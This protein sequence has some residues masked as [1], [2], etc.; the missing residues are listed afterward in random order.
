MPSPDTYL[1]L[2][3][4]LNID[5]LD[6]PELHLEHLFALHPDAWTTEADLTEEYLAQFGDRLPEELQPEL[7]LLSDFA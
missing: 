3:G 6:L 4:D 2:L 7:D 5:G 1:Y